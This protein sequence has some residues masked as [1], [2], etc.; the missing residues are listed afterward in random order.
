MKG[1]VKNILTLV[2]I[3][4]LWNYADKLGLFFAPAFSIIVL[5]VIGIAIIWGFI[6][7]LRY[8]TK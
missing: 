4:I 7:I 2:L 6:Y 8:I 1:F 3:V 5:I